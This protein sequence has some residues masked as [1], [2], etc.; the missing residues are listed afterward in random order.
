MGRQTF[1][2]KK[3]G[4]MLMQRKKRTSFLSSK[5][6]IKQIILSMYQDELLSDIN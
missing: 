4:T 1:L 2:Q 6:F 3:G 5:L